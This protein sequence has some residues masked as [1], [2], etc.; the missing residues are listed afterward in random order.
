MRL[1]NGAPLLVEGKRGKGIVLMFA[2]LPDPFWTTFQ[3]KPFFPA[4]L[5]VLCAYGGRRSGDEAIAGEA[6]IV[7]FDGNGREP[8]LVSPG[9]ESVVAIAGEGN[10]K[11][12]PGST[13]FWELLLS[14]PSEKRAVAVNVSP[15]E[16][17]PARLSSREMEQFLG[18][19]QVSFTDP[20]KS[21]LPSSRRERNV[22]AALILAALMCVAAE[23]AA[24]NVVARKRR[25]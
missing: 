8:R 15:S 14:S 3:M 4:F 1:G 11:F 20:G 7:K 10:A 23:I 25:G 2:F 13:G 18:D 21:V 17:D 19:W 24:G 12:Q 5:N 6:A 9:G 16:S 22:P